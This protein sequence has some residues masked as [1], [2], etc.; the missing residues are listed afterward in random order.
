[1][2]NRAKRRLAV[3]WGGVADV[4]QCTAGTVQ[5]KHQAALRVSLRQCYLLPVLC[6]FTQRQE[7]RAEAVAAEYKSL[8]EQLA[9]LHM[10]A[11]ELGSSARLSQAQQQL[12]HMESTMAAADQEHAARVASILRRLQVT[13]LHSLSSTAVPPCKAGLSFSQLL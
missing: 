11:A 2:E 5:G 8:Q 1:M 6:R 7:A 13:R 12:G 10:T 4:R 3:V 9:Q